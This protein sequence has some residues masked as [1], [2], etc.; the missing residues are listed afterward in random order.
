MVRASLA[1]FLAVCIF[2]SSIQCQISLD[3]SALSKESRSESQI[4]AALG[5]GKPHDAEE[6][7]IVFR[8]VLQAA[9]K[10]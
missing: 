10:E 7:P 6:L 8:P 1:G 2:G 4:A 5:A 3:W 9:I